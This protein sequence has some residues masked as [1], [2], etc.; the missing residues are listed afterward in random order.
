MI[1]MT[2]LF[3]ILI[4]ILIVLSCLRYI[5]YVDKVDSEVKLRSV[6]ETRDKIMF[7]F[8]LSGS[9]FI[10]EAG[11]DLLKVL[12]QEL[13]DLYFHFYFSVKKSK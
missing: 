7:D 2:G 4:C 6:G 9:D 12:L 13:T 10:Q 1:F 5:K 3:S 11:E 8:V